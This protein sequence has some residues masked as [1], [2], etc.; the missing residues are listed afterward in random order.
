MA[1]SLLEELREHLEG[2]ENY[3][4]A[5]AIIILFFAV[6][7]GATLIGVYFYTRH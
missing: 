6:F 2:I 4:L 1:E 5:L 3:W 7:A